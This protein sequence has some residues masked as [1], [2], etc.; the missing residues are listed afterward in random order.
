MLEQIIANGIIAGS[1]YA[2]VAL[3]FT[4]IYGT[5]R[6]FHFAHGVVFTLAAYL[7]W[8]GSAYFQLPLAMAAILAAF[9]GGLLGVLMNAVVYLPLRK[10]RAP[11][12]ILLLA[13]FGVFVFLQNFFQL[14]FG[15]DIKVLRTG[16]VNEGL[17]VLGAVITNTQLIILLATILL[18]CASILF[19]KKTRIGKA[20]CA[21]ADDPVAASI[22]GVHS[23]R[24]IAIVFFLGSSLAGAAGCLV[25]LETNI[26]PMMGLN[27]VIKGIIAAVIGGMGSIPGALLG[28]MLIGL[29]ENIGVWGISTGWKDAISFSILVLF[30]LLRPG[31]FLGGKL[32]ARQ[33]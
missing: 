16:P 26:H 11:K 15:S 17:R 10:Q 5:V 25:A 8:C 23:E 21:V 2:L 19:I 20:I 4:V 3:G 33:V 27:A 1:T 6:F 32:K 12:L 18:A 28:G 14:T 31:G 30:L 22:M 24:T 7:M 9:A 13:S 29:A